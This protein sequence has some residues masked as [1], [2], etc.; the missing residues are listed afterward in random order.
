MH[1]G[2]PEHG[3]IGHLVDIVGHVAKISAHLVKSRDRLRAQGVLHDSQLDVTS[4][5][6]PACKEVTNY[7]YCSRFR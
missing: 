6:H 2:G 1:S 5:C 3:S 4:L 7:A